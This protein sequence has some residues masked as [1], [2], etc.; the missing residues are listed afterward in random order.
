MVRGIRFLST[1]STQVE[2][3][4]FGNEKYIFLTQMTFSRLVQ[5][6]LDFIESHL[7]FIESHNTKKD[8][9]FRHMPPLNARF[10]EDIFETPIEGINLYLIS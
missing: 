4:K 9:V 6:G 7:D 8:T 2:K 3:P 1:P 10:L 5:E